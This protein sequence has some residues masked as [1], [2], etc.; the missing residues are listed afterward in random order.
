[1]SYVIKNGKMKK[2]FEILVSW[3]SMSVAII[4]MQELLN[5]LELIEASF[6]APAKKVRISYTFLRHQSVGLLG[7]YMKSNIV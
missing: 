4:G 7:Y 1:M 5:A 3:M 2:Y 6:V